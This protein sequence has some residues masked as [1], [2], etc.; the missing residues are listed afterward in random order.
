MAIATHSDAAGTAIDVEVQQ[1]E[2][3]ILGEELLARLGG[4]SLSSRHVAAVAAYNPRHGCEAAGNRIQAASHEEVEDH[5]QVQNAADVLFVTAAVR[6]FLWCASCPGRPEGGL[7][8]LRSDQSP[9]SSR[10][11]R[12]K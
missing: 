8:T 10:R 5:F 2:T 7:S 12:Q 9:A 6:R 1:L 11:F 3:H 4:S